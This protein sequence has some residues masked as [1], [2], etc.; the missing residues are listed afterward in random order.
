MTWPSGLV[1]TYPDVR[2]GQS[3][4]LVEGAGT[5]EMVSERLRSLPD[6][7]PASEQLFHSL[8]FRKGEPLPDLSVVTLPSSSSGSSGT[9]GSLLK[10]GRK[11]VVNFWATWCVPCS[12]EMPELSRLQDNSPPPA[13]I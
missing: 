3:L 4:R 7:E 12:V 5:V 11:T 1:E 10:P 6:P 8:A 9:L 13:S 2:A